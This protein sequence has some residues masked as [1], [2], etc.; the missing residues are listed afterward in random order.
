MC[1]SSENLVD[2]SNNSGLVKKI[3]Q[4]WIVNKIPPKAIKPYLSW[5]YNKGWKRELKSDVDIHAYVKEYFP[6]LYPIYMKLPFGV[7]RADIWRY[8]VTYR[9]GGLYTDLDTTCLKLVDKWI[10]R[11]AQFVVSGEAGTQLFCQWTFYSAPKSYI[12]KRVIEIMQH[13][14]RNKMKFFNHMVH[15]YTG[16][17]VFTLGI[18]TAIKELLI[19]NGQKKLA[20]MVTS[21]VLRKVCLLSPKHPLRMFLVKN[22]IFIL[23]SGVF[24]D[25]YVKHHYGGDRW[26]N[27]GY[28]PWKVVKNRAIGSR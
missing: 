11:N 7:M 1:D 6:S 10:P 24:E 15:F 21:S 18:V 22:G 2:I 16:P 5:N 17:T 28:V 9:E 14:L 12:M 19:M 8:C 20:K 25:L 3:W 27:G 13:R 26:T 23:R 4:T